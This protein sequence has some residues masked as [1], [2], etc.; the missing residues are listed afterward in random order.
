[1]EVPLGD[2]P[3]EPPCPVEGTRPGR[4]NDGRGPFI[5]SRGESL[6]RESPISEKRRVLEV[7]AGG[8][9][10]ACRKGLVAEKETYLTG[11]EKEEGSGLPSLWQLKKVL[12]KPFLP[13]EREGC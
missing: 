2:A 6:R 3:C 11:I 4:G 5:R 1:M 9:P 7:T 8:C 13:L 10:E 12:W